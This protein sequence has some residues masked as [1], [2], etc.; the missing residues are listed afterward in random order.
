M[1][2]LSNL[3]VTGVSRLLGK[4][5][6]ND[7]VTAPKFVGNLDGT[8]GKVVLDK[9]YTNTTDGSD[10]NTMTQYLYTTE[11]G[12]LYFVRLIYGTGNFVS[13][14][15]GLYAGCNVGAAKIPANLGVYQ[16]SI[17][18][19]ST[20]SPNSTSIIGIG[21]KFPGAPATFNYHVTI[22]KLT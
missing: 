21:A 5:Y 9:D 13:E 20:P 15:Y 3:I 2:Q 1:A 19:T 7:T 17:E 22:T 11:I 6:V 16:G 8:V 14:S 10:K 4:L 12:S 18:L